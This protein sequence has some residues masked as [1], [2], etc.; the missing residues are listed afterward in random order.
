MPLNLNLKELELRRKRLEMPLVVLSRRSGVPLQTLR[1]IL[2]GQT[3]AR[4]DTVVAVAKALGLEMMPFAEQQSVTE[5]RRQ[6]AQDK[7]RRLVGLAQGTSGLEG[8]AVDEEALAE[9]TAKTESRLLVS[10]QKLW[11]F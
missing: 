9:I 6:Q 7:A 10:K 11:S 1:R 2:R 4:L 8:Q 3:S 5:M